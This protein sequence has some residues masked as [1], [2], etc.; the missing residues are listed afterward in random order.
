MQLA[1]EVLFLVL[2]WGSYLSPTLPVHKGCTHSSLKLD[3]KEKKK[4]NEQQKK[5]KH[6]HKQQIVI[7]SVEKNWQNRIIMRLISGL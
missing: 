2:H 5:E 6:V 1:V 7:K 4:T 3:K